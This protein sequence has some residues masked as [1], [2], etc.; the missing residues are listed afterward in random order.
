[1]AVGGAEH[2][3]AALPANAPMPSSASGVG[4]PSDMSES[5]QSAEPLWLNVT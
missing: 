1:M 5:G 4:Y 3:A 2:G